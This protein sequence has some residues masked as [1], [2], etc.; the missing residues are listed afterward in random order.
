M[1]TDIPPI[2]GGWLSRIALSGRFDNGKSRIALQQSVKSSRPTA[3][4]VQRF[5]F[6]EFIAC[7]GHLSPDMIDVRLPDYSRRV[8]LSARAGEVMPRRF[9]R[10]VGCRDRGFLS[11]DQKFRDRNPI[12]FDPETGAGRD[13]HPAGLVRDGFSQEEPSPARREPASPSNAPP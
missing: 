12:N 8:G 11:A 4:P 10:R 9:G 3:V 7:N 6:P 2:P 5:A 13:L 1:L